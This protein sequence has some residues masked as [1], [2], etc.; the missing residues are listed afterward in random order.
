MTRYL[1]LTLLATF[2]FLNE[3]SGQAIVSTDLQRAVTQARLAGVD[4]AFLWRVA[5]TFDA[6]FYD[7]AIRINLTNYANVPD[8]SGHY[9][10]RSVRTVKTFM[11]DNDS[12]LRSV[13][14]KRG[15]SREIVASIL[16][17]ESRCGT[18]TGKFHV[19]SVFLSLLLAD[20]SASVELS[21]ANVIKGRQL[22]S[23]Q[24]DSVRQQI[25]L[26][27]RNKSTWSIKQLQALEAID[28]RGVMNVIA[29]K[30]SWAGA[31]GYPQFIPSSYN[32][33]A[34]DGN[35]DGIIDLYTL[36]DA[37]HSIANYL[38]SNGWTKK[39]AGQQKAVHH[40]NNSD[41]YVNA[42]FTLAGKLK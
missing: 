25:T 27:A 15:V 40:Y 32:S 42:V 20:D 33:W 28:R 18:T 17:I 19:P 34:V 1:L 22:D 36:P 23:T 37:A 30:G 16:W 7:K 5:S 12:L 10:R 3:S 8:Y 38:K 13:E 2:A 31:F 41:A 26:R 4:S 11:K 39:K 24:L 21:V 14:K 35:S 29:L 9:N 6:E